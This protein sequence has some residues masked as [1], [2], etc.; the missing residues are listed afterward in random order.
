MRQKFTL[1]CL[2]LLSACAGEPPPSLGA[3]DGRLA[4]CPD[5]PNCVCSF[6]SRESHRV[7]PFQ[8]DIAQVREVLEQLDGAK[9]VSTGPDYL[10]AE[11]SSRIFGFVDDVELLHDPDSGQTHIRS[12]SRVGR[13]DLGVN[14]RRVEQIR[15]LLE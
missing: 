11:F 8:A 9:I 5:S 6:E 14:R 2:P 13:S 12:A 10:H 15:L 4:N 1:A 3:S 7:E